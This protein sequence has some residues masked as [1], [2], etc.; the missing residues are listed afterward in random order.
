MVTIVQLGM[1]AV[2]S[3]FLFIWT[4]LRKQYGLSL[5]SGGFAFIKSPQISEKRESGN[6]V[7]IQ[8]KPCYRAVH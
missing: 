1:F 4:D 5:L 6:K 3:G 2:E 8:S 7:E